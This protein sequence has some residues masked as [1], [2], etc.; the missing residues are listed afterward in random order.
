MKKG[1]K[2]LIV[3]Q[4][5]MDLVVEV[6][7]LI[8]LLPKEEQFALASQMRRA[9]VSIPSNIAEGNSR[10]TTKEYIHFLNIALG[11]KAE[12]ETQIEICKRLGYLSATEKA[13]SLCAEVRK[14]LNV[15]IQ[16]LSPNLR[17][18]RD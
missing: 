1:Y 12:I 8:K 15:I 11:S 3:W 2:E 10:N 17:T 7:C 5:S 14:M 13:D 4:K 6:Y 16:K 18:A 9:A